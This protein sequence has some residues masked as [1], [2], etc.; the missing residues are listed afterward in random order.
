VT[1]HNQKQVLFLLSLLKTFICMS[2][3]SWARF[4]T[5]LFCEM[6]K[7][8]LESGSPIIQPLFLYFCT[9]FKTMKQ[10]LRI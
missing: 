7:Y 4:M 6:Q 8:E 2:D 5:L 9:T 3:R 1:Q 10:R